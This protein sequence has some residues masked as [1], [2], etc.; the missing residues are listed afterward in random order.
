[1][2]C[3]SECRVS[4]SQ[5]LDRDAVREALERLEVVT[6]RWEDFYYVAELAPMTMDEAIVVVDAAREWLAARE[7]TDEMVSRA[8]QGGLM[9]RIRNSTAWALG[10]I[11]FL[12]IQLGFWIWVSTT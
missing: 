5:S 9:G 3:I 7:V 2:Q 8:Q 6:H 12:G 4:D 1:M 11:L 10:W